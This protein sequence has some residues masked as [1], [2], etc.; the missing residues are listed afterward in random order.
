MNSIFDDFDKAFNELSLFSKPSRLVFN[1][2]VFDMKPTVWA[3]TDNGYRAIV[4]TL[5][6]DKVE[7]STFDYGVNIKGNNEIEGYNYNVDISLPVAEDVMDDVVEITHETKCGVTIINLI[8]E[9]PERRKPIIT[10]K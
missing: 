9:R 8:V 10:A 3:K 1:T 5:G 7:V 6:L 2:P 4:K